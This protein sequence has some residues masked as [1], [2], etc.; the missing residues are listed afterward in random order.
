MSNN[1]FAQQ[2]EVNE[3]SYV[4]AGIDLESV[5]EKVELDDKGNLLISFK[6]DDE[7]GYIPDETG[8]R[9]PTSPN[10]GIFTERFQADYIN[11]LVA[12]FANKETQFTRQMAKLIHI[13]KAVCGEEVLT[14]TNQLTTSEAGQPVASWMDK[15]GLAAQ[16]LSKAGKT[17]C[18]LKITYSG[19]FTQFPLFPPFISSEYN[20]V[21]L[22]ANF[23]Y[24]K[25]IKPEVEGS[26]KPDNSAPFTNNESSPAPAFG[27]TNTPAFN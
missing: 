18:K 19:K 22:K 1:P 16:V 27:Q 10:K 8:K 23:P 7:N 17:P 13:V 5:F 4:S 11:G 21:I 25:F 2:Q 3:Q 6:V 15:A 20:N 9:I 14:K 26:G 24:D 12:D